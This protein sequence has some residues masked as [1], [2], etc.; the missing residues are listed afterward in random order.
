M[1]NTVS[2]DSIKAQM[3][4]P[5]LTHV[6]GEPTHKQLKLILHKLTANLM[7]VSCPW[8]H[9]KDHLGLLQIPA[10]YL[11]QNRASFEI[12]AAEPPLY[13]IVPAN[14]TAHQC[15]ELQA[16]STSARKA[17]TAYCL[18]RA[19]TCDQFAAAIDDVFYAVLDNPIKG[20][21][22]INL[23]TLVH[24]IATM[25]TQIIQPDLNDNLADFNMGID[26]GLPLAVYTR[27]QERCQVFALNAAVPISKAI[28]VTTRTKHAL[29]CGNMTMVWLKWNRRTIADHTWPNW[30]THWTSA[31]LEMCNINCMMTGKAAFGANAAEEEHQAHQITAL[32]DNLANAL[33]QKN[34]TID[35]LIA[36]NAQLTQALQEMQA[37]MVCMFPAGQAL[38]S[39]YQPL[40]WLPTPLEVAA[41]PAASPAP[42]PAMMDPCPTHW[43]SVKPA[44]DKQGYCWSHRHKVKVGHTSVT[45]SSRCTGHQTGAAKPTQWG[46]ILLL[47][48]A[49]SPDLTMQ[50]SGSCCR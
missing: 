45:C 13:P 46:G 3:P 36:S 30:K 27:K 26:L 43:G 37:A 39:P 28:M 38:A 32:L 21:K 19:I 34:A 22:G 42:P 5:I 9:N 18:V 15:K 11:A 44:W 12:P 50:N 4:H 24:H 8:G 20:L 10:L 7:A 25:Y 14:A 35:N 16:Q 47:R 49:S 6:Q 29:A 40:T 48:T 17:W 23:R 41:P 33:I 31:F 2:A 1:S